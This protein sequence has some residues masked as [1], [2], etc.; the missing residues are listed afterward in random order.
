MNNKGPSVVLSNHAPFIIP[1][2][3]F[4][5]YATDNSNCNQ[6]M[7]YS[8]VVD[9]FKAVR[10]IYADA[11]IQV[12]SATGYSNEIIKEYYEYDDITFGTP[13]PAL[14]ELPASCAAPYVFDW[15]ATFFP[16]G[17]IP[18]YQPADLVP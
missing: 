11:P 6:S 8:W 1:V 3:N 4:N 7:A 12:P 17:S 2:T 5:G 14:F 15:C 13:N 16:A 10:R 9:N 18:F